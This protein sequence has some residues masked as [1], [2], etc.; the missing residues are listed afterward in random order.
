MRLENGMGWFFGHE[1]DDLLDEPG[2][3]YLDLED[4]RF[5]VEQDLAEKYRSFVSEM[6]RLSLAGV[7]VFSFIEKFTDGNHGSLSLA[8]VGVIFFAFSS[9]C[10]LYFMFGASEGLRWYIVGLRHSTGDKCKNQK[11]DP[12]QAKRMLDR[13]KRI[14]KRCRFSKGAAAW[15]LF[16][17]A[18]CMALALWPSL[19]QRP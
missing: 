9:G 5:K 2:T 12:E 13:R 11:F 19:W 6:L 8:A 14:L 7:A 16:G 4:R 17:G 10:S 3:A 18:L 1:T 15:S